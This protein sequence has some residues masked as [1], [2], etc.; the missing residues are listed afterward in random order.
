MKDHVHELNCLVVGKSVR[1]D[2]I[3]ASDEGK[4]QDDTYTWAIICGTIIGGGA[5]E[6]GA[7][8]GTFICAAARSGAGYTDTDGGIVTHLYPCH[9]MT[10]FQCNCA[11]WNAGFPD[12]PSNGPCDHSSVN[13]DCPFVCSDQSAHARDLCSSFPGA[14]PGLKV[15][16]RC[17]L[18]SFLPT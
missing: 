11:P 10:L 7:A 4:E 1:R 15:T 12:W 5:P 14:L 8:L 3:I 16:I 9:V 17:R 18:I 2:R 6:M 13:S